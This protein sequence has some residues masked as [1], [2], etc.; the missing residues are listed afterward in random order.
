MCFFSKKKNDNDDDNDY[1][2][3]GENLHWPGFLRFS[4]LLGQPSLIEHFVQTKLVML[5]LVMWE[6]PSFVITSWVM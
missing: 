4:F 2:Y 6:F 3:I 5:S 1:M